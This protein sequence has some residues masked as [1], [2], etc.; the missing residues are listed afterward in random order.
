MCVYVLVCECE[1]VRVCLYVG[2]GALARGDH[3]G[4]CKGGCVSVC[5]C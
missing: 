5:M 4:V 1:G 3:L 2:V